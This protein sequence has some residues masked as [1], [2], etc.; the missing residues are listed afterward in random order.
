MAWLATKNQDVTHTDEMYVFNSLLKT[1]LNSNEIYLARFLKKKKKKKKVNNYN[2]KAIDLTIDYV[3]IILR[4]L[5]F[6]SLYR[7][8]GTLFTQV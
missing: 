4:N 8:K 3:D 6:I 2:L 7:K 5:V 1:K